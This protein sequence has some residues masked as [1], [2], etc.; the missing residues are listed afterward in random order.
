LAGTDI[1]VGGQ[2]YIASRGARLLVTMDGDPGAP[3]I[4]LVHGYPDTHRVWDELV[5]ALRDRYHVVAYDTRGTGRSTAPAEKHAFALYNLSADLHA[6][7]DAVSPQRPVHL[8]GHDWGAFQ[9]WDAV[10]DPSVGPRIASFTAVAGPRLDQMRPW[11]RSRLRLNAT[12]IRQL[13]GQARRSWYVA[14]FQIPRLPEAVLAS[15]MERAWPRVMRR[16]EHVEPRDG[17]P[18]ATLLSDAQTGLALYR[19]NMRGYFRRRTAHAGKVKVGVPVQVVIASRDRYISPALYD[20]AEQWADT[21]W[22]REL[23]T[24]H[25]VQR[26]HPSDVARYISQLVEHTEPALHPPVNTHLDRLR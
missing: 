12:A 16:L 13:A 5:E 8:V 14:A 24:G 9:C 19:T 7:I 26:S 22:R 2:T 10:A 6:V 3:T 17:H 23:D 25:W 1:T 21:V 11:I 18:A 4:V 15:V 20:E